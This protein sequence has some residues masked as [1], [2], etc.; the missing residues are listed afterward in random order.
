MWWAILV[1]LIRAA[2]VV[3]REQTPACWRP[4]IEDSGVKRCGPLFVEVWGERKRE[5]EQLLKKQGHG[6]V[7]LA[8]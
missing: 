2:L 8:Q 6:K 3:Q 1:T 5:K 4:G 7:V